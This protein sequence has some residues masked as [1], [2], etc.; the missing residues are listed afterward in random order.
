MTPV[1]H[2]VPSE[3]DTIF[4]APVITGTSG[5]EATDILFQSLIDVCRRHQPELERVLRG[6]ANISELTPELM[7]R[8][9]QVQG[10][11]FQLLSIAEENTAMRRRRHT[12]S[13]RGRA[14]V[15]GTFANVLAQAVEAGIPAHE[16]HALLKELR[17]RPTL[18]AHPTEAKRVTML[19]KLRRIYLVLRELELPR[20]TERER[21]ALVADLRD[22]IELI[23]MTG[24][25]QLEKTTVVREVSWGLHFFDESLFE[26]LPEVLYSLEETLAEYYPDERFEVPAFFQFGSWIGGDRDGNPFVTSAVTRTTLKRNARASM[27]RYRTRLMDLGRRLSITERA[28][29]TSEG[30]KAE[31]AERLAASGDGDAIAGRNPGEPYRQFLTCVLGKLDA[32]IERNKEEPVV[33]PGPFYTNADDLIDDLKALERGLDGAGCRSL[34]VNMV[35]PVRRMVEIFRFSTVRLDLRENS[36]RTTNTLREMWALS[37][38]AKPDDA[39]DVASRA[40]R[41]W[42]SSELATPRTPTLPPRNL[43]ELSEDAQETI[44]TFALV[45][46]M[47][48]Q[49]DREAFGA[50]IL[51]MTRSVNDILGAYLLAKEAGCFLD[52][53]GVEICQL[54]IVPLFETIEDLREGPAIMR[55]LLAI[56][57]VR[58]ST[59]WQGEVQEVMIG[60]SDSNK[61]GGYFASNWELYKAQAKLTEVGR[62]AGVPIAF[63]HGR[64]GSVSRGGAPTARAI[65]AQP[66]GSIRGRYRVTDQGEIV[67]FKYSNRGT[68]AYQMELTASSVFEHALMSERETPRSSRNE[69]DDALE[70]L[71]GASRATYGQLISNEHLV[72]YF[73]HASP[74]EELSLLNIGSR[75]ARR[76]GA[77]SLSDLRAIPWVFAWAQNRHIITGWYGIGSALKN[78]IEVR[79]EVGEALLRRMFE[80]SKVLRLVLDEVEKTLRMVDLSIARE[81]ATLCPDQTAVDT[82]FPMIEAEYALTCEMALRASRGKEIAERYPAFRERLAQRLP[83]I[84][85]VSREQVELLRRFRAETDEARREDDIKPPLL[86]SINCIA[87][88]F[89]ATG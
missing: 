18:T 79:G 4:A 35:R 27:R 72:T 5:D 75:P 25:L 8:A 6:E 44:A 32:T 49:I 86:L 66:P 70:A 10:I 85:Q 67:S 13:T 42:L 17:I 19:E 68:A 56:P 24:E 16:L 23:W 52:G 80:E 45:A 83:V 82:I 51:S 84:N 74:L 87:N 46:E 47:R 9:L 59:R 31:L 2:A 76:F 63:F 55:E 14:E 43:K 34:A 12:E 78:F 64:G 62:Q 89:G 71:S 3:N 1:P 30:F 15:K 20:W 60:Y 28:L 40:W 33:L 21:N 57:V 48:A 77:R 22:Q 65:A 29:P 41:D 88:G 73:Q 69:F 54:P 53:A 61:D 36:T 37:N 81:Y 26:T 7:A 38:D 11:W 58:R 39:P 50:F